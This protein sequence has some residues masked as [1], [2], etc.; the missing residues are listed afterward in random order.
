MQK[1]PVTVDLDELLHGNPTWQQVVDYWRYKQD[2]YEESY[3]VQAIKKFLRTDEQK[4]ILFDLD[5]S[6][7]DCLNGRY[8]QKEYPK[9]MKIFKEWNEKLGYKEFSES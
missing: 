5:L 8:T 1:K 2:F 4:K 6:I 3:L 9:V 7:E